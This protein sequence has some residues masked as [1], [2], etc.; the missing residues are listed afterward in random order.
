MKGLRYILAI[1]STTVLSFSCSVEQIEQIEI[2]ET[3]GTVTR[4]FTAVFDQSTKTSIEDGGKVSWCKGDII[5]YYT[6]DCGEIRSYVIDKDCKAA[7]IDITMNE[8]DEFVVAYYGGNISTYNYV[9]FVMIENVA[10]DIQSGRFEDAHTS[11]AVCRDM[12][13]E[14][15][16]FRNVTSL[17]KFSLKRD[18]I[19]YVNISS[20]DHTILHSHGEV[21]LNIVDDKIYRDFGFEYGQDIRVDVNGSGVFYAGIFPTYLKKGLKM[22]FLDKDMNFIGYIDIEK[23]IE[24]YENEILNFGELDSRIIETDEEEVIIYAVEHSSYGKIQ[25]TFTNDK[26]HLFN[27][28]SDYSNG[29]FNI[30]VGNKEEDPDT[31]LYAH[32]DA[33]GNIETISIGGYFMT[34][35]KNEYLENGENTLKEDEFRIILTDLEDNIAV[36]VPFKKKN[37]HSGSDDLIRVDETDPFQTYNNVVKPVLEALIFIKDLKDF[38]EDSNDEFNYYIDL[39]YDPIKFDEELFWK[40]IARNFAKALGNMALEQLAKENEQI[41]HI[42]KLKKIFENSLL[43]NIHEGLEAL[44]PALDE[45]ENRFANSLYGNSAPVTGGWEQLSATEVRLYM[46]V[47]NPSISEG[48]YYLGI[49]VSETENPSQKNFTYIQQVYVSSYQTEY[50]FDF[51]VTT[52]TKYKYRAFLRPGASIPNGLNYWKYGREKGFVLAENPQ[53]S[54]TVEAVD[55]GLSVKW[56]SCNIGAGSPEESGN[57]YAWGEIEPK[58]VY[59]RDT[60]LHMTNGRYTKYCLHGRDGNADYK[61]YLDSCDDVVYNTLGGKWDIPNGSDW[62]NLLTLCSWTWTTYNGVQG[63]LVTGSNG[64][65]IFLPATG[66]MIDSDCSMYGKSC[67]YWQ[68]KLWD[69]FWDSNCSSAYIMEIDKWGYDGSNTRSF[70]NRWLGLP[71]RAVL[72]KY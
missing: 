6:A 35:C 62:S 27:V 7:D 19:K 24:L 45:H 18:D 26:T 23:P 66:Y 13:S 31:Y 14:H 34:A 53:N 65:S 41:G 28:T 61:Y 40:N 30:S 48:R 8:E 16:L 15:L 57:Y 67:E 2:P 63:Y 59:N 3:E 60:Y 54:M 64:N 33:Y 29:G 69:M 11:I 5:W 10:E 25:H 51:N 36:T 52:G 17:L 68:D 4:T 56:A 46:T 22:D 12:E 50:T 39:K 44:I 70:R 49:V 55:L 9:D 43:E 37:F 71:V 72:R 21:F 32:S 47:D 1:I 20:N 42:V 58:S 38:V